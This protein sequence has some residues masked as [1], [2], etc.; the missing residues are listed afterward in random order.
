MS[1]SDEEAISLAEKL[2]EGG[3][4]LVTGGAGF[5]GSHTVRRLL[6]LGCEVR[7][8]DDLSVGSR[9]ALPHH[10]NLIFQEGDVRNPEQ[11][12]MAM[13]GVTRVLHLAA[14]VS[15][16]LSLTQP[17]DSA[18]RNILGFLQVLEAVKRGGV[19][20]LVFASS[21][22]VYGA[23]TSQANQETDPLLPLSPYGLE[24]CIN[25]DYA[26]IYR[27]YYGISSLALRYFNVYGPG[28][29]AGSP[30]SGVL[31]VFKRS[32]ALGQGLVV[33]G[34]GEQTRDFIHVE[35]IAAMNCLAL[36]SAEG[37][38]MNVATGTS[39][40]LNRVLA[41]FEDLL[42]HPIPRQH[43]PARPEDIVHS[44]ADVS[45]LRSIVGPLP[46]IPL[47]EGLASFLAP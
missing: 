39:H 15:T 19:K 42:G 23:T 45:R 1:Q 25:E 9:T 2:R 7:V 13:T 38:C 31:S 36:A 3:P 6:S 32:L 22:A 28:Q 20:R 40:S 4:I 29:P 8:L 5:I 30:Y 33:F 37:G 27:E 24:K 43:R 16:H 21:A 17:L 11:V 14:Q 41:I 44:R 46:I 18:S 26:R 10:D 35:S 12:A 47:E 34:D